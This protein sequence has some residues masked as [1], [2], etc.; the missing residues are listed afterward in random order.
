MYHTGKTLGQ[1][2]SKDQRMTTT[3]QNESLTYHQK[4]RNGTP[5]PPL[6]LSDSIFLICI[7][8]LLDWCI[9]QVKHLVRRHRNFKEWRQLTTMKHSPHHQK[10]HNGTPTPPLSL[11]D[12][13]FLICIRFLLDWCII[14]VK[15]LVRRHQ[16]IKE[17]RQLTTMKHSP[18]HQKR[19]NGT[20]TPHLRLSESIFLI[21]TRC[22]LDWCIIQ[23]KHMVRRHRK[24]IEWRQ[25]TT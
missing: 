2:A 12:S 15:H 23:V 14:Q 24:I 11:S 8:C 7:R 16:K 9:I 17:S 19:H 4:R 20:L 18:H 25:L 6:R 21:C 22:L 5:T 3:D 1:K 10:R 13:I